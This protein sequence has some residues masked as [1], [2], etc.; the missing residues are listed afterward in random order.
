MPPSPDENSAAPALRQHIDHSVLM[1]LGLTAGEASALTGRC[2]EA[3]GRWRQALRSMQLLME[4]NRSAMNRSGVTRGGDPIRHAASRIWD[5]LA[6]QV[7]LIPS[8]VL[9]STDLMA[10]VHVDARWR[11]G[12][13]QPLV[14]AGHAF[15][16]R[17]TTVDLGSWDR[18]RYAGML[19][20]LGF[21]PPFPVPNDAD[22]CSQIVDQYTVERAHLIELTRSK[23]SA[24]TGRDLE[25][26][27]A[28]VV[29]RWRRASRNLGSGPPINRVNNVVR[30]NT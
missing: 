23:A 10:T 16:P 5:E 9:R 4:Q 24:Y 6:P 30:H 11:P 2:Y 8:Q 1:V 19:L 3:Y 27:I 18:V 17:Q 14:N 20:D 13:Q 25:A 15:G 26:L 22:R 7:G 21:R 29:D 12:P 28:H